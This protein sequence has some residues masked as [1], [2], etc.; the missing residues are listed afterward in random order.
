MAAGRSAGSS[1]PFET[2]PHR[3]LVRLTV[4]VMLSLVV[5]PL[6]G[7]V[8]TAFVER[9]GAAYAAALGAA[10]ALLSSVLWIFNF[11]GVGTQSEVAQLLGKGQQD[12]ARHVAGLAIGLALLIGSGA[13]AIVWI[14]LEP[15]VAWMSPEP[16]VQAGTRTYVSIRLLGFPA[17]LVLL[18]AF[19]ALRG[20]QEM[21]TPMWI[22]GLMSALNIGLDAV[23]IFGWG[24]IP[25]MGIAGAAW[26]TVASQ[27]AAAI[28]AVAMVVRRLGFS[29]E[30]QPARVRA[31]FV[32]GR[33]MVIRTSMLLLFMLIGT[34]VALQAGAATGAAHQAIR[35][36]WMLLAFLLDAYA[37][38]AQSLI[39][40]FVGAG[41]VAVAR[42]VATMSVGWGVGTGAAITVVLLL[43]EDVVA[44]ALV[45]PESRALFASAWRIFAFA[46][47]VT[48][49]AFVTDG[50]HWGTQDYPYLRNAMLVS[51]V[52]G[53]ACLLV[54]DSAAASAL[55]A[56][57][58]A[59]VLWVSIRAAAGWARIWPGI[60]RSPLG[61]RAAGPRWTPTQAPKSK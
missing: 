44:F 5:E 8:D 2:H 28:I 26:A 14:T 13:A 32:V 41:R 51:S 53:I 11:L 7:V 57:W 27:V 49:V 29:I 61:V 17:G 43:V 18:A 4:P 52:V 3:T 10:T 55:Q 54:I 25:A 22:A 12:D 15:V 34:R 47:P 46:Q 9:L 38:S 1:H 48:A 36:M 45:P 58:W 30:L 59:T 6:A 50:V 42:R 24:A 19:G 20:L 56:V 37:A 40:Y 31:L 21:R 39:G 16:L 35:Q 23:L 60:G 33:D